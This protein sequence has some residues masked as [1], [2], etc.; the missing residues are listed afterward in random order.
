MKP[1]GSD[2]AAKVQALEAAYAALALEVRALKGQGASRLSSGDLDTLNAIVP[3][4]AATY[5]SA[6]FT[7]KELLAAPA[8]GLKLVLGDV[9]SRRLGKLLARGEGTVIATYMIEKIGTEGHVVIRRIVGVVPG[10]SNSSRL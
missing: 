6:N 2:L 3:V 9:S 10:V 1:D 4:L 5:G 8:P 7:V